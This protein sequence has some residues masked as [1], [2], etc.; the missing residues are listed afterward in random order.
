MCFILD[1]LHFSPQVGQRVCWSL[2]WFHL[3][4]IFHVLTEE[5]YDHC[6]SFHWFPGGVAIKDHSPLSTRQTILCT[7]NVIGTKGEDMCTV[8][9]MRSKAMVLVVFEF[10]NQPSHEILWYFLSC[11]N[12]FFKHASGARYLIFDRTLRLLPNFMCANNEDTGETA[13]K[14]RLA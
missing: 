4:L 12:S 3:F 5:G 11:V 6:S 13:R 7:S 1:L 9:H 10:I 14:R 2:C 8:E